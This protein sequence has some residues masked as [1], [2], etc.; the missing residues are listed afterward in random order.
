MIADPKTELLDGDRVA[1][2]WTDVERREVCEAVFGLDQLAQMER[3][4][5]V[6]NPPP[7]RRTSLDDEIASLRARQSQIEARMR[8]LDGAP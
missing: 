6:H 5:V 8:D 4:E 1:V 7:I 2:R 3:G